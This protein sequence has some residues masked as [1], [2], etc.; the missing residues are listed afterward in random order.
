LL[1]WIPVTHGQYPSKKSLSIDFD[2]LVDARTRLDVSHGSASRI[3]W[4]AQNKLDKM[5]LN[6]QW[7]KR[8][9]DTKKHTERLKDQCVQ[10]GLNADALGLDSLKDHV[11]GGWKRPMIRAVQL[12]LKSKRRGQRYEV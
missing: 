3:E 9:I 6:W 7:L 4:M 2:S 8:E 12:V 1:Y 10:L 11:V 5:V